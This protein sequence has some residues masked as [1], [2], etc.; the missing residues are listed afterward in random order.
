MIEPS[1]SPGVDQAIQIEGATIK[2]L[3]VQVGGRVVVRLQ[4]VKVYRSIPLGRKDMYVHDAT[5]SLSGV[6]LIN[7]YGALIQDGDYIFDEKFIN[8]G[9]AKISPAQLKDQN[10]RY[11][12][13]RLF[14]C[15]CI[16][17]ACTRA[18]LILSGKGKLVEEA[19]TL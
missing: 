9:G 6:G 5:L 2:D 3:R 14:S 15:A 11:V 12:R 18:S 1:L 4:G 10:I 8:A 17:I 13:L 19:T 16:G 7:I